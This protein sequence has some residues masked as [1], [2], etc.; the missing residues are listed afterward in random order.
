MLSILLSLGAC[1]RDPEEALCP[2]VAVGGLVVTEVRGPQMMADPADHEWIE[3]YNASGK[4]LD[5]EGIRIRFRRKDG[6]NEIPVIVRES[7]SAPADSY[8]V[9]GLFLND[10][11]R[12]A[13][14]NY[15][16]AS[17]FTQSW[18]AAAAIDVESCGVRIDRATYDVLPKQGTF[19]FTGAKTPETNDN[20]DLRNWC[21]NGAMTGT[22]YP[23]TPQG[24]NPACP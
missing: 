18:L 6:S 4:A 17:D 5:L 24:A 19:S 8:V 15:G 21:I 22:A 3:L 7:V 11:N 13:Y 1:T 12:P 10:A 16:F 23:G 20:D 9:L 2:D 14:V